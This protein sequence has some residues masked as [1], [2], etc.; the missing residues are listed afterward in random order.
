MWPPFSKTATAIFTDV[1]YVR[2]R[3]LCIRQV[4]CRAESSGTLELRRNEKPY[5]AAPPVPVLVPTDS[6][7]AT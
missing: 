4:A 6:F 3:S 1:H 7:F 2:P 5:Q